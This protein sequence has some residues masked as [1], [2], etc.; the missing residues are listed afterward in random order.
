MGMHLL[1]M[2]MRLLQDIWWQVRLG[3]E[4]LDRGHFPVREEWFRPTRICIRVSE[5][6]HHRFCRLPESRSRSWHSFSTTGGFS[7]KVPF[8]RGRAT[9]FRLHLHHDLHTKLGDCLQGYLAH[10]KS[11]PPPRTTIG[12]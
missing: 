9:R 11:P 8:L 6:R 2:G 12:L 1:L 7:R 5:T 10:K 3:D 4:L